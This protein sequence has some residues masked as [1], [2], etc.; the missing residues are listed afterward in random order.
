MDN[1]KSVPLRVNITPALRDE[2]ER[3]SKKQDVSIAHLVRWAIKLY[4]K[5][6][7]T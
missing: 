6:E 1:G 4:L 2:L 7:E 3:V 5:K